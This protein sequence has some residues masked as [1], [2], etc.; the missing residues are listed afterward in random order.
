MTATRAARAAYEA[1]A[2]GGGPEAAR[3]LGDRQGAIQNL[4]PASPNERLVYD[5]QPAGEAEI[6]AG[7]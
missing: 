3:L 1:P 7:E 4:L 2:C 6:P 5:C